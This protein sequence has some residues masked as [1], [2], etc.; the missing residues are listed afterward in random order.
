ML[1]KKQKEQL[2]RFAT[3][4][5]H[6]ACTCVFFCQHIAHYVGGICCL[7]QQKDCRSKNISN[8]MYVF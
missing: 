6:F 2:E 7:Q 3:F 1:I 5:K 4:D 8:S